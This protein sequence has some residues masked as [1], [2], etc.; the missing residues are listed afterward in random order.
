MNAILKALIFTIALEYGLD[1]SLFFAIVIQEN[2]TL[3]PLAVYVNTNGTKDRGLCQLNDSWFKGD[4][5]D[6]ETNIRAACELFQAL[7]AT[8]GMNTW[9]A[10]ISYNAGTSWFVHGNTPPR[11]SIEYANAVF[12]RWNVGAGR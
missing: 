10:V 9:Q 7:L 5:A 8:P 4:W 1:P 3:D 12:A 11:R 2:P 6:P